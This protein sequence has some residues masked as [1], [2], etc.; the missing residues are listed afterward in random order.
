MYPNGWLLRSWRVFLSD[1]HTM[2]P[3]GKNHRTWTIA[4]LPKLELQW[5]FATEAM[6]PGILLSCHNP[7]NL[8]SC[9]NNCS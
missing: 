1:V 3:N 8:G 4:G 5:L 2:W 9:N 6:Q 7:D